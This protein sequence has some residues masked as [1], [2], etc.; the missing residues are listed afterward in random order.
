MYIQFMKG[1][2]MKQNKL[3]TFVKVED[4]YNIKYVVLG[5]K[6]FTIITLNECKREMRKDLDGTDNNVN[7]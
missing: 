7:G 2:V 6:I 3:I 1:F 4:Y 5:W